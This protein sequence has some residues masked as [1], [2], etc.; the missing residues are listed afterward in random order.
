MKK[1]DCLIC[2]RSFSASITDIFT[3][4]NR[5]YIDNI[6]ETE[7]FNSDNE[8]YI[9]ISYKIK[10]N[11]FSPHFILDNFSTL[12]ESRKMKIENLEK[13]ENEK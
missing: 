1:G 13:N 6:V 12:L 2:K 5:Y 11:Y 3:I 4:N 10:G 9:E 8:S 7:I